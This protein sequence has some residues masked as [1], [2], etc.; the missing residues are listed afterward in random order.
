MPNPQIQNDTVVR[1][2]SQLISTLLSKQKGSGEF[3]LF[4]STGDGKK[5]YIG[6]SP[7]LTAHIIYHLHEVEDLTVQAIVGKALDFLEKIDYTGKR[8]YKFWYKNVVGTDFPFLPFDLDDTAVVNQVLSLYKRNSVNNDVLLNNRSKDKLFYTWLKP[9]FKTMMRSPSYLLLF[10]EYV[11]S[12]R[13][14]L[15]N[16]NNLK[17]AEF[18][19]SEIIVRMNVYIMMAINGYTAPIIEENFPFKYDDVKKELTNSLHYNNPSMY[20]LTIAKFQKHS[21]F[22]NTEQL[23]YLAE[24]IRENISS[25]VS[26]L[27]RNI[28]NLSVLY[29]S[30]GLL[31]K[32]NLNDAVDF[33]KKF[34]SATIEDSHFEVCVGNKKFNNYHTYTSGDFTI[35]VIIRLLDTFQNSIEG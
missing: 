12:Y 35:A 15:K 13:I 31:D 10:A 6:E 24:E 3:E 9:S 33:I 2:K 26:I 30:L 5:F 1:L 4:A 25:D 14:F 22:L 29:L 21:N 8:V 27:N 19:D 16:A 23:E 34:Q 18:D 20:Y 17:M 7:F 28:A 11:K 32:L